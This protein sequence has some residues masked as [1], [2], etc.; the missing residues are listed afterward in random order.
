MLQHHGKKIYMARYMRE[1]DLTFYE[2]EILHFCGVLENEFILMIADDSN[3]SWPWDMLHL[4][5]Y[6]LI[7][8]CI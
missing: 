1:L 4:K 6:F 2:K 3:F 7:F 5:D 8:L